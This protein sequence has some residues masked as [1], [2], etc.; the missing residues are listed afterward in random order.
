[1]GRDAKLFN[2]QH[3][4]TAL[5]TNPHCVVVQPQGMPSVLRI[6]CA[7]AQPARG[8]T[9]VNPCAFQVERWDSAIATFFGKVHQTNCETIGE[10]A[11]NTVQLAARR[12]RLVRM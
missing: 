9:G 3:T 4:G 10:P 7:K 12:R 2:V 6:E 8:V 11:G 5:R 1:M